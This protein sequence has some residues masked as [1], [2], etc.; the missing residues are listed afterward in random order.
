MGK[1]GILNEIQLL[2]AE[3]PSSEQKIATY[4]AAYPQTVLYI[5]INE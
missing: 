1:S 4:I 5:T 3:L 2:F